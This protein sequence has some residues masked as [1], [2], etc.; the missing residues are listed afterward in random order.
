VKATLRVALAGLS[1]SWDFWFFPKTAKPGDPDGVVVADYGSAEAEE[2]RRTGK[3]LLVVGNRSDKANFTMGWWWLGKQVGTAV[4]PHACLGDFPY[5][6]FLSPLLFRIVKEGVELPVAGYAEEDYVIVGEGLK[7]AYLYLAAKVRPDGGREVYV[8]G[9]DISGATP[10]SASLRANL[11]RW[12]IG[13]RGE[14][15][16]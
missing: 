8:S 7:D 2:A 12:L 6:P 16:L 3:N 11:L 5:E 15:E 1:N 14:V 4:L 9:L 13:A 10:E